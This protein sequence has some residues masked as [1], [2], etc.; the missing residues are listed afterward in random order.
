MHAA[1][2]GASTGV[3]AGLTSA[4]LIGFWSCLGKAAPRRKPATTLSRLSSATP[5]TAA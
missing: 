5:T 4:T 1:A 3:G 2:F